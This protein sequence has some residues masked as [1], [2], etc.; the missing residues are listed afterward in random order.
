M[1]FPRL[2]LYGLLIG[3][4]L[5]LAEILEYSL[6]IFLIGFIILIVGLTYLIKFLRR[7]PIPE[8]ELL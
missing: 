1:Q 4:G 5:S 7:Y 3:F 6:T 2:F 8:R